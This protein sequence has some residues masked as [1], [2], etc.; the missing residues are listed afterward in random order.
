MKKVYWRCKRKL[1]RFVSIWELS[2]YV[3]FY[4]LLCC[5]TVV[6]R[7][8]KWIVDGNEYNALRWRCICTKHI[9]TLLP[10]RQIGD[11]HCQI[12]MYIV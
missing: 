2:L 5:R 8:R 9:V 10:L 1:R 3:E 12:V 6:P 11:V 4:F 7:K